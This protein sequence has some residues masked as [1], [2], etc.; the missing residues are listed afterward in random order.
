MRRL[1][2]VLLIAAC[3]KTEQP[4]AP[5]ATAADATTTT[6]TATT[7]SAAPAPVPVQDRGEFQVLENGKA[8]IAET[9]LRGADRFAAEITASTTPER[10]VQR[11]ML[12]PDGSVASVDVVAIGGESSGTR[13]V[14]RVEG[15]NAT[16]ERYVGTK[17]HRETLVVVEHSIPMPINES[18]I[19]LEQV[20]LR[21]KAI[22]GK[23][24]DVPIITRN[25]Q[26]EHVK[27]MFEGDQARVTSRDSM[28]IAKLD[29]QG[30]LLAASV[31]GQR[32]AIVRR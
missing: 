11:A 7:T 6:A 18:I 32:M 25:L 20:I 10:A 5:T 15:K 21:A 17:M 22:G 4:A 12:R 14:L 19:M 9:F 23:T 29:A 13:L 28:I 1:F 8:I 30:R 31:P 26:Q 24:V 3:S 16:I 27:V 2:F